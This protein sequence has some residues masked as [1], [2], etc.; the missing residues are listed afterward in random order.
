MSPVKRASSVKGLQMG[1]TGQQ[2]RSDVPTHP[3]VGA[4]HRPPRPEKP[5]RITVD[6]D[7][8]RHRYLKGYALEIDAKASQVVREL[9]D[10][11]RTDDDL[12]ARVRARIW[13]KR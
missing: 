1:V 7:P 13:D 8:A 5:V 3:P 12:Q 4:Q 10:E 2:A 11:L 6:L 9:L